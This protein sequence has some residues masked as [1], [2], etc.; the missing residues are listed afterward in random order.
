[1][2]SSVSSKTPCPVLHLERSL[3]SRQPL[4]TTQ[5]GGWQFTG[6]KSLLL[7]RGAPGARD[8]LRRWEVCQHS[9]GQLPPAPSRAATGQLGIVPPQPVCLLAC[10]GLRETNRQVVNPKNRPHRQV[11]ALIASWNVI[12][13]CPGDNSDPLSVNDLRQT[14]VIDK[15]LSRLINITPCRRPDFQKTAHCLN[16]EARHLHL[17]LYPNVDLHSLSRYTIREKTFLVM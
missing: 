9:T 15:E 7:L 4:V 5:H 6:D 17:R 3:Q 8:H 2:G 10:L 11:S 14:A 12:T 1:M 13:M 16:E